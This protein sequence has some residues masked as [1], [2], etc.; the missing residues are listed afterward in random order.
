MGTL[1]KITVTFRLGHTGEE[2]NCA[3]TNPRVCGLAQGPETKINSR[4][5]PNLSVLTDVSW[6][7]PWE[8]GKR[9]LG[10]WTP[11]DWGQLCFVLGK[12]TQSRLSSFPTTSPYL[13]GRFT[14]GHCQF[15]SWA[16]GARFTTP[17]VLWF[18]SVK[19]GV[20]RIT[21]VHDQ[22]SA[23]LKLGWRKNYILFFYQPLSEMKHFLPLCELAT[24]YSNMVS[25]HCQE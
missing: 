24:K 7:S 6:D 22:N 5:L 8:S 20:Y 18:P 10:R 2:H 1:P 17:R 25:W 11:W 12:G 16:N 23:S 13:R 19:T 15:T 9:P 3:F 21:G 14:T 4:P